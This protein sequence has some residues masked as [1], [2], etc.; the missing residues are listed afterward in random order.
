MLR[1][2]VATTY[3]AF[4]LKMADICIPA[5][6]NISIKQHPVLTEFRHKYPEIEL[7]VVAYYQ[8]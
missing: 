5:L 7:E 4:D 2:A 8:S 1:Y 6:A 3:S